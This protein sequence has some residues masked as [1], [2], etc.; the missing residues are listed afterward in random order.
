M[1]GRQ[2]FPPCWRV[3]PQPIGPSALTFA[4]GYGSG[5]KA[6]TWKNTWKNLVVWKISLKTFELWLRFFFN[7][8]Q[9]KH[10]QKCTWKLPVQKSRKLIFMLMRPQILKNTFYAHFLPWWDE[11]CYANI[12]TVRTTSPRLP[13]T[14]HKFMFHGLLSLKLT[15]MLFSST[16]LSEKLANIWTSKME[17]SFESP[18]FLMVLYTAQCKTCRLHTPLWKPYQPRVLL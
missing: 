8:Q 11:S 5:W 9:G 10:S 2:G 6:T 4:M 16:G 13:N 7:V 14:S 18:C 12:E 1:E 3:G 15:S 17:H